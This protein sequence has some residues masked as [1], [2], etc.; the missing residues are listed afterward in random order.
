M[1]LCTINI[2]CDKHT[3]LD[4]SP[5]RYDN[6][7]TGAIFFFFLRCV[8]TWK[9]D[10]DTRESMSPPDDEQDASGTNTTRRHTKYNMQLQAL[11]MITQK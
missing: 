11:T 9:N 4:L 7:L 6:S 2:K 3:R 10:P 1:I 8:R 5:P